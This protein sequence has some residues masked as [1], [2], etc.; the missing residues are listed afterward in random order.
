MGLRFRVLLL[1]AVFVL[2]LFVAIAFVVVRSEEASKMPDGRYHLVCYQNGEVIKDVVTV[3]QAPNL[4]FYDFGDVK[5]YAWVW[6]DA[7]GP[8]VLEDSD[9]LSCSP[10][11]LGE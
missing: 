2:L 5:R 1:V 9:N 6:T 3:G 7:D 4:V 10:T 11:F 8:Q